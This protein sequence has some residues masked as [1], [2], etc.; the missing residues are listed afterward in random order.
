MKLKDSILLLLGCLAVCALIA[1]PAQAQ[2]TEE[3]PP[4]PPPAEGCMGSND[5]ACGGGSGGGGGGTYSCLDCQEKVNF[6]EGYTYWEC[7]ATPTYGSGG[8]C[9]AAQ[10]SC[11]YKSRCSVA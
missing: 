10:N 11:Y 3:Q 5:P 2:P 4:E 9:R 6:W 8:D 7:V 1:L